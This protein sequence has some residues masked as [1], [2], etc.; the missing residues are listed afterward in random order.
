[1]DEFDLGDN[2]LTDLFNANTAADST[3][4]AASLLG[5]SNTGSGSGVSLSGLLGIANT[6]ISAFGT[7]TNAQSAQQLAQQAANSNSLLA[8]TKAQS[9]LA[10]TNLLPLIL[11]IVAIAFV[12]FFALDFFK[13]E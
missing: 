13:K 11:G 2:D 5:T 6:G 9:S 8:A 1:M 3:S 4:S 7:I 10:L 12:G